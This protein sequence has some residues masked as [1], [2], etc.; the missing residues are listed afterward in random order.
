M[1]MKTTYPEIYRSLRFSPLGMGMH[2]PGSVGRKIMI[3][4]Y[5][6]ANRIFGFN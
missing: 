5:T 1:D 3:W 2:L 4:G 6:L